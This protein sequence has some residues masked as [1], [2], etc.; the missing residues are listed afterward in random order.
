MCNI[1]HSNSTLMPLI[2]IPDS[3]D[4]Q[5]ILKLKSGLFWDRETDRHQDENNMSPLEGGEHK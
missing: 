4:D 3:F 5:P 1:E 2:D